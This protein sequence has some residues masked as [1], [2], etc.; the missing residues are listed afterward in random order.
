MGLHLHL[1][2]I[3][4][5]FIAL[6]AFVALATVEEALSDLVCTTL[7]EDDIEMCIEFVYGNW[8]GMAKALFAWPNTVPELCGQ[9]GYCKKFTPRPFMKLGV[10]CAECEQEMGKLSGIL[11]NDDFANKVATDMAGPIYCDNPAFNT[12]DV[13]K[14]KEWVE[15]IGAPSVKSLGALLKASAGRI[16]TDLGCE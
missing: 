7:P 2:I 5:Y 9:L 8:P 10:P 6:M 16:C 14:C 13:A 12:G 4:K 1:K 15:M 3:M 11:S